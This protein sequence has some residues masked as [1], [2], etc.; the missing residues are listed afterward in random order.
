M[1]KLAIIKKLTEE[2]PQN[3]SSWYLLG[4]EYGEL[5]QLP[6]ALVA[7]SEALKY[8][9]DTMRN[10]ILV[11]I[12]KFSSSITTPPLTI[13]HPQ[14][15]TSKNSSTLEIERTINFPDDEEIS[16]K[17][18]HEGKLLEEESFDEESYQEK[19]Y[20]EERNSFPFTVIKGGMT[21]PE[22]IISIENYKT[23]NFDDVGGLDTLKEAIS[24][25]IIKPFT[26][27]NLF[28][29]F[30]KKIGGGILLY[31]PPGCGKTFIAQATAGECKAE[32]IPVHITDILSKYIGESEENI[33]NIFSTARMK[34]PC[35]LFFDEI[36]TIAYNRSQLSSEYMRPA[37]DQL[38]TEIE[39]IDANTDKLLI[40]G[41]TN[42]PWD[43]DTAFKR[44]GRFDKAI[45]VSPP[46][47][48]ARQIIFNLKLKDKPVKNIDYEAL[49]HKT[50]LYS[51][52]DI[53]NVVEVAT[54]LVITEIMKTGI[55]RS[56]EMKDLLTAINQTRP[57]T[58]EWL[59][60]IKNYVIYANQSG[61][62]ND[63]S[64]YLNMVKKQ[65]T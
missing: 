39:G 32:F 7:F 49:S 24:M 3:A 44:P 41:A 54:E 12:S 29:R 38:L 31:G 21:S 42:M 43:V 18:L 15:D 36:D 14:E 16:E 4:C 59:R 47:Y 55:D 64:D 40:L 26:N 56:I 19:S 51:G 28:S 2:N 9:D 8:C 65:L 23:I 34:K 10:T 45:F 60:T 62:Y 27:T 30:K 35:V 33:S 48:K 63:V 22:K 50:E 11:T 13:S 37:I 57:S 20:E 52:A 58:I 46:D 5:N 1:N 53:E 25:K 6:E 61:V 17:K